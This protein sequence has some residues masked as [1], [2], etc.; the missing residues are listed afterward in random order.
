[1]NDVQDELDRPFQPAGDRSVTWIDFFGP[2]NL[3]RI[4][5]ICGEEMR[6]LG[7]R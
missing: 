4:E 1:M 6:A 2:Q 5:S 7:Y 3:A